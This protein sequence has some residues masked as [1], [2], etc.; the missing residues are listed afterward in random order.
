VNSFIQKGHSDQKQ[1]K[2][3][4]TAM[5]K[6]SEEN[7]EGNIRQLQNFCERLCA[8]YKDKLIDVYDI[9][10]YFPNRSK[11]KI[12]LSKQDEEMD[13]SPG[14]HLSE[15]ERIVQMLIKVNFNKGKAAFE[16][17]MSR[18]TL[19]RKMKNLNIETN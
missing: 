1:I 5:K 18:T 13:M 7:W 11:K 6:L 19:W 15:R 9:E 12:Q 10:L 16:L 17:G 2:I 4:D 14:M 8:L 3:T